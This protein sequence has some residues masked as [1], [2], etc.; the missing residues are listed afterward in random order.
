MINIETPI[1]CLHCKMPTGWTEE[2]L[3][4]FVIEYD[5]HCPH[6]DKIVI[7]ANKVTW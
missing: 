1:I 2:G 4:F 3:L 5:M 7:Y 6:C